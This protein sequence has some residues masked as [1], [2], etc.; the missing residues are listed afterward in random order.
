MTIRTV[1]LAALV[2]AA[3]SAATTAQAEESPKLDPRRGA[4][5]RRRPSFCPARTAV[6]VASVL[7]F[8]SETASRSPRSSSSAASGDRTWL[9]FGAARGACRAPASTHR[10]L[11][12]SRPRRPTRSGSRRRRAPAR[13]RRGPGRRWRSRSRGRSRV[14]ISTTSRTSVD[15]LGA[16]TS[17]TRT[18]GGFGMV[19]GGIAVERVLTGELGA[20]HLDAAP[21]RQLGAARAEGRRRLARRPRYGS[22]VRRSRRGSSCG[23][24]SSRATAQP[25]LAPNAGPP[26][27]WRRRRAIPRGSLAGPVKRR[28]LPVKTVRGRGS[29]LAA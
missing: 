22:C 6:P 1:V 29:I 8:A 20:A 26:R 5:E 17:V 14:G 18:T 3:S 10:R 27:R 4:R 19:T 21:R 28:A 12:A 23:S 15:G 24:P 16:A 2:A 9:V 25:T 11:G 7:G 13:R